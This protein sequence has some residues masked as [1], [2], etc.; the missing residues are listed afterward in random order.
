MLGN[1]VKAG[2]SPFEPRA[3]RNEGET[4]LKFASPTQPLHDILVQVTNNLDLMPSPVRVL[5]PLE[6]DESFH[7]VESFVTRLGDQ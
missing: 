5:A 4:L 7:V 6:V 3:R 1:E 2:I